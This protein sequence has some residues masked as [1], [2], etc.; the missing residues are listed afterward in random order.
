MIRY[1]VFNMCSSADATAGKCPRA[2]I[3]SDASGTLLRK[4]LAYASNRTDIATSAYS[5][6][7]SPLYSLIPEGMF[8]HEDVFKTTYGA[9][10]N[11][12]AA[13]SL[14]TQAGYSTTNKLSL[15]LWYTPSHYGDPEIFVAQALKRFLSVAFS[16]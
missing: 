2:T 1:L 15:T 7:V 11:I 8:G 3:F 14:L 6:T 9:S 4:A 10:P 16:E 12:A 13:Q 5:N